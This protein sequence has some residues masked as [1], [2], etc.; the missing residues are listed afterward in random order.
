[1]G[2]KFIVDHPVDTIETNVMGTEKILKTALRYN[3]RVLI[4]STSE[5]YGKGSKIPFAEEDDVLLGP[6]HKSRW[7]YAAS[8]MVDEFLGFAYHREYGLPVVTARLFNTVGPRQTGQ[9]GMVIPRFVG[10]A[11]KG[12]PITVY[13]D[14]SQK[15]CFCDVADVVKA[16]VGLAFHPDAVGRVFN[17]GS[18]EEVSI[19]E[20]AERVRTVTHS[21]SQVVFV[22]YSQA[23]GEG[24]EDMQR[25]VP[26]TRRIQ[27]LLDWKPELPL[28]ETLVRVQNWMDSH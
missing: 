21:R 13:E 2:V 10:Q 22:P 5:V 28:N 23:Y 6:T 11:L 20:L 1:V 7:A 8:K 18:D 24:F 12:E 27:S 9:Y 15:R 3:C 16:L 4:A 17:V 19:F 26:D 25:R 14:G